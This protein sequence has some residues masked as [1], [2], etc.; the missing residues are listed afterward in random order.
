V[1]G[2]FYSLKPAPFFAFF[3]AASITGLN[4]CAVEKRNIRG[5]HGPALLYKSVLYA[6]ADRVIDERVIF[7]FRESPAQVG[8]PGGAGTGAAV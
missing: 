8:K 4:S 3:N 7:L 1:P 5:G 2:C 6:E